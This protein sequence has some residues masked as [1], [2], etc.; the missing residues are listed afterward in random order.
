[1]VSIVDA[2]DRPAREGIE[3]YTFSR[4]E[5]AL[6]SAVNIVDTTQG[7]DFASYPTKDALEVCP[8]QLGFW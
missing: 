6:S 8:S 7:L 1:M 4:I 5:W 2:Q 3:I